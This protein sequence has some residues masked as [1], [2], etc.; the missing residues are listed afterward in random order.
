MDEKPIPVRGAVARHPAHASITPELISDLVDQFYDRARLDPRIGPI[1]EA[2]VR[3]DWGPH[4]DKMKGFWR[5]VLLKTAEYDGRP[6]PAHVK[7]GNLN[8]DDFKTWLGLFEQT[9]DE[10]FEPGARPIV[11]DAARRIAASLWIA[12]NGDV[13]AA[14]PAWARASGVRQHSD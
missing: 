9:V 12:T 10:I 14:P 6:V 13:M 3:G 5:S 8:A 2:Q 1:F 11:M 4:L 7:I